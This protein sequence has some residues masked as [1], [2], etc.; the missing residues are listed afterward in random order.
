MQPSFWRV[1]DMA[2]EP[3]L[4]LVMRSKADVDCLARAS[5]LV[6]RRDPKK[7]GPGKETI[8]VP[9]SDRNSV[10]EDRHSVKCSHQAIASDCGSY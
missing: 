2:R 10:L 5:L 4:G 1:S 9:A 7:V 3:R 8:R 6:P